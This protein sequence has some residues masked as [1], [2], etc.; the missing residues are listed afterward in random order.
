MRGYVV[1]SGLVA[2]MIIATSAA[3]IQRT[4][5][6]SDGID[7][8]P[9]TLQQPCRGFAAA[10]LLTDPDGEVVVL[11]SAGYGAVTV[12]KGVSIVAPPGVYAGISVFAGQDGVT[13]NP[14]P[15][16]KVV[17]HG[18]TINGQG[19]DRGII[20]MG[21]Y[22]V[23]IEA[24]T[25]A[26]LTV[27]GI[28]IN[29]GTA[30]HV[31]GSM[32]RDIVTGDGIRVAVGASDVFVENTTLAG[33]E[34]GIYVQAGRITLNRVIA[35]RSYFEGLMVFPG[36]PSTVRVAVSDSVFAGNGSGGIEVYTYYAGLIAEVTI[37]RT[38]AIQ[39]TFAGITADGTYGGTITLSVTESVASENNTHGL[40]VVGAT[41]SV[42]SST[43]SNNAR[44]GIVNLGVGASIKSHGNNAADGN[45]YGD[46]GGTITSVG[47]L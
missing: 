47:L 4:F 18:L 46:T 34:V 37:A 8:N 24:C 27:A 11:D 45:G 42:S 29:G 38:A 30:V 44:Y 22:D 5:V 31:S 35:Q 19:G 6:R 40:A 36:A 21:G 16:D 14:A 2:T 12:T 3:G 10:I 1:F 23:H 13:I 28:Q 26:N 25:I 7:S 17:L 41:A 9:C 39:N 32:I 15:G 20:V 43:F 33:N